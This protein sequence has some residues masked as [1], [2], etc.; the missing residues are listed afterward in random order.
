MQSTPSNGSDL[1][2]TKQLA[3]FESLK[4]IVSRHSAIIPRRIQR[5]VREARLFVFPGRAHEEI[6]YDELYVGDREWLSGN[7]FL[8]FPIVAVAD[9]AS[10]VLLWDDVTLYRDLDASPTKPRSPKAEASPLFADP[11]APL[12]MG[13]AV[14]RGFLECLPTDGSNTDEFGRHPT[15]VLGHLTA[16]GEVTGY[17]RL[18]DSGVPGSCSVSWGTIDSFKLV[19]D[20]SQ[21]FHVLGTV[22]ASLDATPERLLGVGGINY[23][24]EAVA[25]VTLR[26]VATAYEEIAFNNTPNRWVVETRKIKAAAA[27]EKSAAK[28]PSYIPGAVE[29][30]LYRMMTREQAAIFFPAQASA[31]GA[32]LKQG[33]ER[34]AHPRTYRHP[35][36]TNVRG[37]TMVIPATWVGPTEAVDGNTKHRILVR[38]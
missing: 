12:V 24:L 37:R 18:G 20:L 31:A 22:E 23:P 14:P 25:E 3:I 4:R 13:S 16:A 27:A 35:R 8:P 32:T 5:L 36:F 33:H 9:T 17:R 15:S 19:E 7:F 11:D 10:V 38:R 2:V 30:P 26:N 1:D 29:R 21:R 28:L 34:S 6:P